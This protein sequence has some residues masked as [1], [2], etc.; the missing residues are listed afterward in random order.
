MK[1]LNKPISN[2]NFKLFAFTLAEVLITLGIIGVVASITIPTLIQ[3]T[4]KQEIVGKVKQ[5]YSILSQATQQINNDCG[6][7]ISGCITSSTAT[8]DNDDTARAEVANLYKEKL[9]VIKECPTGSTKGCFA[10]TTYTY[11]NATPWSNPTITTS[12]NNSRMVLKNGT[13]IAFI[14]AGL[15]AY[16]PYYF[17][18]YIDINGPQNPN[19]WGKDMFQFYYDADKKVLLP[20]ANNDCGVTPSSSNYGVGCSKKVLNEDA[21]NYY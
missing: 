6:G 10:D 8:S 1:N 3:N 11:L 7:D 21:I 13:V 17:W 20:R 9:A 4:Q 16:L 15:P 12:Y 19:Q 18:I 14:W 2:S 5:S